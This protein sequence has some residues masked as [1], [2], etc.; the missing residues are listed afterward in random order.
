[1]TVNSTRKEGVPVKKKE[2][3]IYKPTGEFLP[4]QVINEILCDNPERA[5]ELIRDLVP[6]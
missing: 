5:G 2:G 6:S 1:V 4:I 3:Y